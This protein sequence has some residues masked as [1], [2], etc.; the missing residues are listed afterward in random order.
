MSRYKTKETLHI[1]V[2][3]SQSNDVEDEDS[4]V[5][6]RD[7]VNKQI[8]MGMEKSKELDMDYVF[9]EDVNGRYTDNP[10]TIDVLYKGIKN[11]DVKNIYVIG[12]DRFSRNENKLLILTM[13][14]IN[15][16]VS[17]YTQN[18]KHEFSDEDYLRV[19]ILNNL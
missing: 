1:Y 9:I 16:E 19:N 12:M 15:N 6:Y 2:R 11:G 18:G 8:I 4:Y 14:C 13:L 17:I 7:I 3:I 5:G 10:Q